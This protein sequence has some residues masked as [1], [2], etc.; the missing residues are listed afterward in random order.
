MNFQAL[1]LKKQ[2]GQCTEST[3]KLKSDISVSSKSDSNSA[4]ESGEEHENV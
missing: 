4:S 2:I 3:A 1:K